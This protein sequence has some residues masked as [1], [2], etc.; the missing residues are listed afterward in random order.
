[1]R[2]AI[3][4]LVGSKVDDKLS[5]ERFSALIASAPEDKKLY[6]DC[7]E[8]FLEQRDYSFANAVFDKFILNCESIIEI[9]EI[10]NFYKSLESIVKNLEEIKLKKEDRVILLPGEITI[11]EMYEKIRQ[12]KFIADFVSFGTDGELAISEFRSLVG[13][14]TTLEA[15]K[16]FFRNSFRKFLAQGFYKGANIVY[17]EF[18][19]RYNNTMGM[20]DVDFLRYN[21]A[22]ISGKDLEELRGRTQED[23]TPE[24]AVIVE[25]YK[26]IY[27]KNIT[28]KR[29]KFIESFAGFGA[30][31]SV[32]VSSFSDLAGPK[33][34]TPS[35][36][37]REFFLDS[38]KKF[39]DHGFYQDANTVYDTFV[40][41][42]TDRFLGILTHSIDDINKLREMLK[43]TKGAV[44]DARRKIKE[45][46]TITPQQKALVDIH[47]KIYPEIIERRDLFLVK[48]K[49]KFGRPA[50][51][52]D[53]KESDA[54]SEFS[55]LTS[56]SDFS[57]EGK[58]FFLHAFREFLVQKYY[59][60]AK[61]VFNTFISCYKDNILQTDDIRDF[62]AL[63][64]SSKLE[65]PT[66]FHNI[67]QYL[68]DLK[69]KKDTGKSLNPQEKAHVEI[70][71][72]LHREIEER[73]NFLM[74][75][76]FGGDV[77]DLYIKKSLGSSFTSR[78]YQAVLD[79][80]FSNSLFE[81]SAKIFELLNYFRQYHHNSEKFALINFDVE[82]HDVLFFE[83]PCTTE[84]KRRID[85]LKE[86]RKLNDLFC[87]YMEFEGREGKGN[88]WKIFSDFL[89]QKALRNNVNKIKKKFQFG[90]DS[91]NARKLEGILTKVYCLEGDA[92]SFNHAFCEIKAFIIA[93]KL[94]KHFYKS[95]RIGIKSDEELSDAI[96]TI[97][98]GIAFGSLT[99][100]GLDEESKKRLRFFFSD[101]DGKITSTFEKFITFGKISNV[102][103][104]KKRVTGNILAQFQKFLSAKIQVLE[105]IK[106]RK[107]IGNEILFRGINSNSG[108][109]KDNI[110]EQLSSSH[111]GASSVQEVLQYYGS[112]HVA[113]NRG[114]PYNSQ[115]PRR[116]GYA[117]SAS[118]SIAV[119]SQYALSNPEKR[120]GFLFEI[121]P[122]KG[123][124]LV[125]LVKLS[126][127][128]LEVVFDQI[129]TEDIFAIYRIEKDSASSGESTIVKVVDVIENSNYKKRRGEDLDRRPSLKKGDIFHLSNKAVPTHSGHTVSVARL[130]AVR[131]ARGQELYKAEQERIGTYNQEYRADSTSFV[132]DFTIEQRLAM[133]GSAAGGGSSISSSS[134]GVADYGR[135]ISVTKIALASLEQPIVKTTFKAKPNKKLSRFFKKTPSVRIANRDKYNRQA[136]YI[137]F[138]LK[139][140]DGSAVLFDGLQNDIILYGYEEFFY[141]NREK[142]AIYSLVP[143]Q[144]FA[145][146]KKM[147]KAFTEYLGDGGIFL[148]DSRGYYVAD[149]NFC[150]VNNHRRIITNRLS[151]YFL[152]SDKD[153]FYVGFT[154]NIGGRV[155]FRDQ[156]YAMTNA[157]LEAE[158]DEYQ[159]QKYVE[160]TKSMTGVDKMLQ[161]HLCIRGSDIKGIGILVL[162][163]NIKIFQQY[164]YRTLFLPGICHNTLQ[165]KMLDDYLAS[166]KDTEMPQPLIDHSQWLSEMEGYSTNPYFQLIEVAKLNKITII[167][168]DTSSSLAV[169]SY[170]SKP[171]ESIKKYTYNRIIKYFSE[172]LRGE[173][174]IIFI[175]QS[176]ST[177]YKSNLEVELFSAGI[178]VFAFYVEKSLKDGLITNYA[179]R[180]SGI[181]SYYPYNVVGIGFSGY[182][183][184]L[185]RL[186]RKSF[187]FSREVEFNPSNL[188]LEKMWSS[189]CRMM[190]M[191]NFYNFSNQIFVKNKEKFQR[192]FDEQYSTISP[193]PK[194]LKE[195]RE[196]LFSSRSVRCEVVFDPAIA[197]S[198]EMK[199]IL[200]E[201]LFSSYKGKNNSFF[202]EAINYS[203]SSDAIKVKRFLRETL[204]KLHELGLEEMEKYF[205]RYE[206]IEREGSF[207]HYM[208][209]YNPVML[210]VMGDVAKSE[211]DGGGLVELFLDLE[212]CALNTNEICRLF[213]Q[214][215]ILDNGEYEVEGGVLLT[216][217]N[218][219]S[220]DKDIF[221]K[222]CKKLCSYDGCNHFS[223]ISTDVAQNKE[224]LETELDLFLNP[225]TDIAKSAVIGI[226]D[227]DHYT[228]II[229]TRNEDSTFSIIYFDPS[230]PEY[231]HP[232]PEHIMDVM[233]TKFPG[234]RINIVGNQFQSVTFHNGAE[235][236]V[237]PEIDNPHSGPIV[238]CVVSE[239]IRG[240]LLVTGSDLQICLG[241]M[242]MEFPPLDK[243]LSDQ[244]GIKLRHYHSEI[245]DAESYVQVTAQ[246]PILAECAAQRIDEIRRSVGAPATAPSV[247]GGQPVAGQKGSS[248][249]RVGLG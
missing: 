82:H 53:S 186:P 32:A 212:R 38:F 54:I 201:A 234:S 28:L 101:N 50:S 73:N 164:G 127:F 77:I 75:G 217:N 128:Y 64:K 99:F 88:G 119:A 46:K 141:F 177:H 133:V 137:I 192:W 20:E 194:N 19:S 150:L 93:S 70:Y 60:G 207:K 115:D 3:K 176:I 116:S 190:A 103:E 31:E 111:I 189:N 65:V 196:C 157:K 17:D 232:I 62:N 215:G 240:K 144:L 78:R 166:E 154:E 162:I 168:L 24:E 91:E 247:T 18:I 117:T 203:G 16:R 63:L 68:K 142:L 174:F 114:Q 102:E 183:S 61:I 170:L 52:G 224:G 169:S 245:C 161:H 204:Q 21:L 87:Q 98:D 100:D 37:N 197:S 9:G 42:Y 208:A 1:M 25:I 59:R 80:F 71:E 219:S 227:G 229:I 89:R 143:A 51:G 205:Y 222:L 47:E 145:H 242:W 41:F 85:Q 4:L 131:S 195:L 152:D 171:V 123:R 187:A 173:K 184:N 138:D 36:E 246:L 244:L 225:S 69:T 167:G 74:S 147:R 83:G 40:S 140:D 10:E 124:S 180:G 134:S 185:L 248:H 182:P 2:S 26:K 163:K 236:E 72:E 130:D 146:N 30:D 120:W 118:F 218:Q 110:A 181:T 15:N 214:A 112:Y 79:I 221:N 129:S 107:T 153:F 199:S 211:P 156:L 228:A 109:N 235:R 139:S 14:I 158:E 84:S 92:E 122:K 67:R 29:K 179:H 178:K 11:V 104:F 226:C 49:P 151:D 249:L 213:D 135:D 238:A 45:G 149:N 23:L 86:L 108:L 216:I 66:G 43:L 239:I 90:E 105:S 202:A 121:R 125:N 44:E 210:K 198:H 13:S 95:E 241:G 223:Y 55:T 220:Y 231:Q 191:I 160:W 8:K 159:Y 58:R 27:Q 5:F 209:S 113:E 33:P 81:S 39:M 106:V 200:E 48:F 97:A 6:L 233:T 94:K 126:S 76:L 172:K 56:P 206:S 22:S 188:E 175:P 243:S 34:T 96:V 35:E 230:F 237:I 136:V 132:T 193:P 165:Q 155:C 7:F 12:E 148:N 57:S